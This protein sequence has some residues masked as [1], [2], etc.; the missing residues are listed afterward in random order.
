MNSEKVRRNLSVPSQTPPLYIQRAAERVLK[1]GIRLLISGDLG[2][3]RRPL[4]KVLNNSIPLNPLLK[5]FRN[6]LFI[7]FP[8]FFK[9]ARVPLCY[10]LMLPDSISIPPLLFSTPPR[11]RGKPRIHLNPAL[12]LYRRTPGSARWPPSSSLPFPSRRTR[13]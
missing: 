2:R 3:A 7:L 5:R 4:L 1:F 8:N 9:V 12:Q 10:E 6:S 11:R 13:M